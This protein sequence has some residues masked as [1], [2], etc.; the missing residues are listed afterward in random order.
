MIMRHARF[1]GKC[2]RIRSGDMDIGWCPFTASNIRPGKSADRCVLF[3]D[4]PDGSR[5]DQREEGEERVREE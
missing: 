3:L 2:K 1:C 4:R 5:G